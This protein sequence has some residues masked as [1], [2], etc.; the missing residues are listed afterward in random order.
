MDH[1]N[2]DPVI[3]PGVCHW[4]LNPTKAPLEPSPQWRRRHRRLRPHSDGV[5][6]ADGGGI[7]EADLGELG[8]E[9]DFDAEIGGFRFQ[10]AEGLGEIE[11][12]AVGLVHVDHHTVGGAGA[13][14]TAPLAGID[15]QILALLGGDVVLQDV[16]EDGSLGIV[17]DLAGDQH[18][19]LGDGDENV[20]RQAVGSAV[21]VAPDG[22]QRPVDILEDFIGGFAGPLGTAAGAGQAE[23]RMTWGL[24][25]RP[26]EFTFEKPL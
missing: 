4:G 3:D 11:A 7:E 25:H 18:A 20:I 10:A 15:F 9:G 2:L 6:V 17:G 12:D 23:V 13:G 21:V 8:D 19:V 14:H 24:L 5:D 22:G 26:V 16:G 1:P